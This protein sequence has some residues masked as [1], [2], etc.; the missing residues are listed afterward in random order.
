MPGKSSSG[1]PENKSKK[2]WRGV[3]NNFAK[4]Y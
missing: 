3:G 1:Q 4:H 2:A